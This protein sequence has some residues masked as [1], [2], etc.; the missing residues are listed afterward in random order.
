MTDQPFTKEQMYDYCQYLADEFRM[1]EDR[2]FVAFKDR[3]M[4]I[5]AWVIRCLANPQSEGS[6]EML[7]AIRERRET[8]ATER[9]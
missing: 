1:Y 3:D 4:G 2:E 7:D 5:V 6:R 9:K 8:V